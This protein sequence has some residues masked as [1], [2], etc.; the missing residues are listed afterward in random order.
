MITLLEDFMRMLVLLAAASLAACSPPTQQAPAPTPEP[1]TEIACNAVA[2]NLT[3]Q[4]QVQEQTVVSASDLSG[5]AIAPGLYDLASAT[6]IGAAT[7]WQGARAVALEVSEQDAAVTFNWAGAAASGP[8]DRWTARFTDTPDVR[9]S[10]TCGRIGD[11]PAEFTASG[12]RLQLRL[13]DGGAGSLEL[14]FER[15]T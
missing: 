8:V 15:R 13:P 10:Y 12:N 14:T 3:R 9:L 1:P 4:V 7:G 11:V 5:G 6:R 2:P